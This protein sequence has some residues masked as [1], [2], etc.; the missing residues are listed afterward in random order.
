M[1][2]CGIDCQ[3]PRELLQLISYDCNPCLVKLFFIFKIS[4]FINVEIIMRYGLK[5]II[6]YLILHT[7]VCILLLVIEI[8]LTPRG[9]EIENENVSY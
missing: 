3:S 7:M 2:Y 6:I 8:T 9:K 4:I 5:K 1:R